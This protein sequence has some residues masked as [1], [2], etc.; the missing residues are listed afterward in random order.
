MVDKEYIEK[1]IN[2]I[3]DVESIN[4]KR[5]KTFHY[6]ETSSRKD[7]IKNEGSL[8]IYS[9]RPPL[10]DL[11]LSPNDN[12]ELQWETYTNLKKLYNKTESYSGC[13]KIFLNIIE[14][15]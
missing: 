12:W 9:A 1:S 3:F 11:Q 6:V 2:L 10:A 13:R 4:I 8:P 7:S 14:K 5:N 15:S